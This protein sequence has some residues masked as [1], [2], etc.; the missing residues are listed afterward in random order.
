MKLLKIVI[1]LPIIISTITISLSY[2]NG[3]GCDYEMQ[4][5]IE[6]G[7]ES[8]AICRMGRINVVETDL[9]T[10]DQWV[11]NAININIG[12]QIYMLV[13]SRHK[14]NDG[15]AS[16]I[17]KLDKF[18]QSHD[19]ITIYHYAWTLIDKNNIIIFQ[20]IPKDE[21]YMVRMNGVI[22]LWMATVGYKPQIDKLLDYR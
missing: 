9:A 8:I 2:I 12:N 10:N 4:L 20:K 3:L 16:T 11:I 18:H 5:P 22:D 14:S 17:S 7:I 15:T 1:F 19:G 6:D 21:I 13:T